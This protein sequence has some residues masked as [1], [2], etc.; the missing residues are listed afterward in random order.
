MPIDPNIAL[1]VKPLQLNDPLAQYAQASQIQN[2]QN[3]NALAQYQLGAAQRAEK[4]QNVLSEAWKQGLKP[5][6][7]I[8]P[9]KVRNA[10]AA[11]GVGHLIPAFEKDIAATEQSKSTTGYNRAR[12]ETETSR[13]TKDKI[14][15]S[16]KEISS[17]DTPEE[18]IASI[19]R[20]LANKDID[21]QKANTL[22]ATL[23][24]FTTPGPNGEPPPRFVEWQRKTLGGLLDAKDK[25][26]FEAPKIREVVAAD[27]SKIY[28][29]ENPNSPTFRQPML[30]PQPAGM[31]PFQEEQAKTAKGQ[32]AVAQNRLAFDQNKFAWEKANPGNTLQQLADGSIVGVNTK[33]MQATPVTLDG[34]V[35]KGK[36]SAFAEKTAV[37][38]KTLARDLT[39]TINELTSATKDGGLIDQSTGSGAGR[40]ADISMGFVGKATPGAIAIGKLQ[41]IAD[42]ALKMVPR[43]EGPQS[44][45]DTAS[46]KQAAGQL[47]DPTLPTEIR[48]QAGREVLRLMQA[49]KNQFA[50]DAMTREGTPNATASESNQTLDQIFR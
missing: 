43:F 44:D 38:Q 13:L 30:P 19:D 35:V 18:V 2:Y 39:T 29:D 47:A 28:V 36:P 23:K 46:Y 33:T 45:K 3:Q 10:L 41:P 5:D 27:G 15:Q 37:Q 9:A 24:P 48:K 1:Q 11:G 7:T 49:R 6:G 14:V 20:H 22:K 50:T 34:Q 31:T 42:M 8:D 16:I 32:L 21:E 25:L 40:L 26:T 17:L 4:T 12:T